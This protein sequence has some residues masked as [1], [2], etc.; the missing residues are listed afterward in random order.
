MPKDRGA[1]QHSLALWMETARQAAGTHPWIGD[2]KQTTL[3]IAGICKL[4]AC[5]PEKLTGT[6]DPQHALQKNGGLADQRYMDDGDI[7][8][9]PTLALPFLQDFDFTNV[10]VA[11]ESLPRE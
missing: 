1:E 4:P 7:M 10:R 5:E 9:H 3:Q 6:H 11:A 8:Y 2:C